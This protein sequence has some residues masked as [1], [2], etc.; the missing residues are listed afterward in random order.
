MF[1]IPRHWKIAIVAVLACLGLTWLARGRGQ[2]GGPRLPP[3][4]PREKAGEPDKLAEKG[5][6]TPL[7][8]GT[9][10]CS[11]AGC[12]SSPPNKWPADLL[13]R[14]NEYVEWE[15]KD[16]HA[17]AY[18][19]L[20]PEKNALAKQ[21]QRLLGEEPLS[22]RAACLACHAVVIADKAVAKRSKE[23]FFDVAEGVSCVACH[24]AAK[25]WVSKHGLLVEYPNWRGT[26]LTRAQKETYGM[27]DL[28]GPI[29]R[30]ELCASCHV[31]KV[32]GDPAQRKFVTHEMYA[33]GH[34]PLPAFEIASF[35]EQMPRHWLERGKKK[36]AA[37][38]KE[39]GYVEGERELTKLVLV[40]AAVS[41]RESMRL[42]AHEAGECAKAP[43]DSDRRGLD[44]ANFDCY[45]C[46]HDLKAD[47]PRQKRGFVGK[48]GR[49]PM[50][51]WPTV[52][53]ELALREGSEDAKGAE[54]EAANY[55]KL[56]EAVNAGFD[57]RPYGDPVK[58]APAARA[59]EKWADALAQRLDE[60]RWDGRQGR[61]ALRRLLV[62]HED[63]N[64][65]DYD[66]A[67]LLAWSFNAMYGELRPSPDS[68]VAKAQAGLEK[69]LE[70]KLPAGRKARTV[71]E[72]QASLNALNEFKPGDF[73]SA[74]RRLHGRLGTK[75]AKE[76]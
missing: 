21:M 39:L 31:G 52:L 48:P 28:W 5:R 27:A 6:P 11:N 4:A 45:A 56:L 49:V 72:R 10:A 76:P 51:P 58:I 57:A 8:Y 2:E 33:A 69:A 60:K 70:L 65:P 13:C 47:S 1:P 20:L 64:V 25:E 63:R 34:P 24:G 68:E 41:L 37:V 26:K 17:D 23:V 19:A 59:L 74:F 3:P 66:S 12:H 67:R 7:Y 44:L 53:M 62:L 46:H 15:K 54:R 35:S 30:T 29:R 61:Q 42:L 50:R 75:P 36:S 9:A 38:R 40:G 71:E 43:S 22:K 14:C 16:K 32:D 55:R 73:Q 18:T